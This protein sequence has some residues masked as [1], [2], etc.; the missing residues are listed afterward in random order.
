[1]DEREAPPYIIPTW[2]NNLSSQIETACYPPI[3]GSE[4]GW[5]TQITQKRTDYPSTL[6]SGTKE[7]RHCRRLL[8]PLP[9]WAESVLS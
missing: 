6:A 3:P 5:I 7:R 2:I 4:S 1:M 9:R 8:G